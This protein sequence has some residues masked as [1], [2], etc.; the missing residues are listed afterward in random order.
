[1]RKR[2]SWLSNSEIPSVPK[3][4]CHILS[5]TNERTNNP[6]YKPRRLKDRTTH[7]E[8]ACALD[9]LEINQNL[10]LLRQVVHDVIIHIV[11]IAFSLDI[12]SISKAEAMSICYAQEN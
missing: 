1:M 10:D 9:N 5:V 8:T 7:I 3:G 6:I 12:D 11:P 4:S 2:A